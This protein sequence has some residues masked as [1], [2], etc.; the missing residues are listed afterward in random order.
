M[1]VASLPLH[2]ASLLE[3]CLN[4]SARELRI[5]LMGGPSLPGERQLVFRGVLFCSAELEAPW[6]P[7]GSV[8]EVLTPGPGEWVLQ[9]QSG[10]TIRVRAASVAL[11]AIVVADPQGPSRQ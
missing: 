4:W 6:G 10:D 7:S 1:S 3:A 11:E 9:M 8:L 5:R 2:D